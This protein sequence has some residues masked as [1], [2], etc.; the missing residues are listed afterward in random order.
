MRSSTVPCNLPH[1][2]FFASG[3]AL[4]CSIACC[5]WH[6]RELENYEEGEKKEMVEL[7]TDGEYGGGREKGKG[8]KPE[9]AQQVIDIMARNKEFFVDRAIL[10]PIGQPAARFPS[11]V[12]PS[13]RRDE[14]CTVSACLSLDEHSC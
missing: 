10:R 12:L 8:L 4:V 9:E 6:G 11:S 13:Q 14:M 5:L 1:R 2:A 3:G 7:Y